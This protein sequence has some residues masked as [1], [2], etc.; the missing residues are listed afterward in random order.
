[1]QKQ[2]IEYAS[3]VD[4]IIAVAKRLSVYETRY[5]MST[6]D[7]FDKFTKGQMDD[8]LD[9]VEWANDYR[10]FMAIKLELEKFRRHAA[11]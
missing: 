1:M 4:A 9:F 7:F 8:G 10:H 6:E 2:R 3:P 5:Q 11:S